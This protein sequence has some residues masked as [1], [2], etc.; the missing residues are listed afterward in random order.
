MYAAGLVLLVHAAS[1]GGEL[2]HRYGVHAILPAA[3]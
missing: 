3:G 1:A 2:V